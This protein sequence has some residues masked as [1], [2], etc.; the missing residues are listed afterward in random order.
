MARAYRREFPFLRC[1][2]EEASAKSDPKERNALLRVCTLL[3]DRSRLLTLVLHGEANGLGVVELVSA[4]RD[5]NQA[6]E[7]VPPILAHLAKQK[8]FQ[9][10]ERVLTVL[11]G[12]QY[13]IDLVDKA[14]VLLES[15]SAKSLLLS[16]W[17]LCGDS[18][19]VAQRLES[20][21]FGFLSPRR[22]YEMALREVVS[23]QVKSN[24]TAGLQS[25][26]GLAGVPLLLRIGYSDISKY[27]A[28]CWD[29]FRELPDED[30]SRDAIIDLIAAN[31]VVWAAPLALEAPEF[32]RLLSKLANQKIR[33]AAPTLL[34][35]N[36]PGSQP[37]WREALRDLPDEPLSGGKVAARQGK[38]ASALACLVDEGDKALIE[39]AFLLR[40]RLLKKHRHNVSTQAL[41]AA[42]L[43]ASEA[44]YWLEERVP[45]DQREALAE[46]L[47]DDE[48]FSRSQR[49]ALELGLVLHPPSVRVLLYLVSHAWRAAKDLRRGSVFDDLYRTYSL[50]KKSGGKREIC[51]PRNELKFIQ[52]KLLDYLVSK[53]TL[54]D[55]VHGFRSGH[56]VLSNASP[57]SGKKVVVNVD[58]D[59][60]FPSVKFQLISRACWQVL[61]GQLSPAAVWFVAEL[62][63]FKGS[64]PAG[65]PTSPAIANLVLRGVD[66]ALEKVCAESG[67]TYTRYADDLTFSGDGDVT[68]IIPFVRDC[69]A[70]LGLSLD[71]Q[72]VNIFRRGRRQMVTG[73]VVN[74]RPHVPRRVRRRLRAA[75]HA[76]AQGGQPEWHG[77]PMN[78]AQLRGR[79]A[80]LHAIHPEEASAHLAKITSAVSEK[81]S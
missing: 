31:D 9:V 48:R 42:S 3:G 56:S 27:I 38:A 32:S 60:F 76:R 79:I 39:Q 55:C 51:V 14:Q 28:Y 50:P 23:L 40:P 7:L 20:T 73:L 78:D 6:V 1:V 24:S 77:R 58:I 41:L 66:H 4:L 16:R 22:H 10:L 44:G 45:L 36:T 33:S 57:H 74:D 21:W 52:R 67:I 17:L 68:S 35:M 61:G 37:C 59:S 49:L 30:D 15:D 26:L 19:A 29:D 5:L 34:R 71:E 65:A 47:R 69:L 53:T 12:S 25:T 54:P 43:V 72:K 13:E 64:L 2:I 46:T 81:L 75:V 8:R 70:K 11:A 62:C 80:F 63:S 18:R